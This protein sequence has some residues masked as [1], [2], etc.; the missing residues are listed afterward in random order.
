MTV[1][2]KQLTLVDKCKM[3]I[4]WPSIDKGLDARFNKIVRADILNKAAADE[5]K[6]VQYEKFT[7]TYMKES[8]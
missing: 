1:L 4:D 7:D 6:D 2:S 3:W 8:Y 5:Y